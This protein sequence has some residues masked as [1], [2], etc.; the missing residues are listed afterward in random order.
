MAGCEITANSLGSMSRKELQA[1]AK[2]HGLKANK[3]NVDLIKEIL[4][5]ITSTK[6]TVVPN[7]SD[8]METVVT[9][10]AEELIPDKPWEN[11]DAVDVTSTGCTQ[12][13]LILRLNKKSARVQL[14][15]GDEITVKFE[16][17]FR[18]T[19]S[20]STNGQQPETTSVEPEPQAVS[21]EYIEVMMTRENH[22]TI[23]SA[24]I[25]LSPKIS[26][27][28]EMGPFSTTNFMFSPRSAKKV[29]LS[30]RFLSMGTPRTTEKVNF[31]CIFY[32]SNKNK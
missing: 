19:A 16:E 5:I 23:Q 22:E 25:F 12:R 14:E 10:I 8:E 32:F 27:A 9:S 20:M 3:A 1:I 2:E 13:G 28:A 21:T 6:P 29:S 7:V 17:M 11:G 18:P 4:E 15:S 30:T 24:D 31:L 26:E